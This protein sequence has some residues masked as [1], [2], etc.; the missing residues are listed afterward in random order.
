MLEGLSVLLSSSIVKSVARTRGV[1]V[2]PFLWD[3]VVGA[4]ACAFLEAF[5][6]A[7]S[8]VACSSSSSYSSSSSELDDSLGQLSSISMDEKD[9]FSRASW[10]SS[11]SSAVSGESKIS[12]ARWI[13][14]WVLGRRAVLVPGS[15]ASACFRSSDPDDSS[16]T[17][18]EFCGS[19]S[20]VE[21]CVVDCCSVDF[22]WALAD[23]VLGRV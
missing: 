14:S 3:F 2:D 12:R 20:W 5:G 23:L 9:L 19:S 22:E 17:L 13:S 15:V 7:G 1:I 21:T 6:F 18:N 10:C 4:E 16:R 11:R 8:L